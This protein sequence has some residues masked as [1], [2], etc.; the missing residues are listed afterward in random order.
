M[1][2]LFALTN[3]EIVCLLPNGLIPVGGS[4]SSGRCLTGLK[5]KDDYAV[6]SISGNDVAIH[7]LKGKK[8]G[9]F[10]LKPGEVLIINDLTLAFIEETG[11]TENKILSRDFDKEL[12]DLLDQ[13]SSTQDLSETMNNVI[14]KM[15]E[16]TSMEK[17]LLIARDVGGQFELIAHEGI[18]HD[19]NWMSESLVQKTLNSQKGISIQN[20]YGSQFQSNKSLIATGFISVQTWPLVVRGETLGIVLVGSL[21]PHSGPNIEELRRAAVFANLASLMLWFHLRD[22]KFKEE[23]RAL[24]KLQK[25]VDESPLATSDPD[26]LETSNMARKVAP[27]N[28][29]VL[30]HGETGVGKELMASW[31]HRRSERSQKPFVAVN[32]GAIPSEL[33]ESLLFGHRKGA[34]TGAQSDQIGKFQFAEGGTL[35]LDEIG[36]L[37]EILQ[38]KLLRVLQEKCIEPLGSNKSLKTDVRIIAASHRS[39]PELVAQGRFREDLYFRLAEIVLEIPPLRERPEDVVLLATSFLRDFAPEKRF[40]TE[41]WNW[42]K[43]QEWR[44]NA[45]ELQSA[46]K[47]AS[48]LAA[49]SEIKILDFTKGTSSAN[50]KSDSEN[51]LGGA[52]LEEAKAHF[53]AEKVKLALQKSGGQRNSAAGLLGVTPRTLFRYLEEIEI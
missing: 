28:L 46:V 48:I 49:C 6:I 12:F 10:S 42:M 19:E 31:I 30:I 7:P 3:R 41:A 29:S 25:N 9:S 52:T 40:S 47:R 21:K 18:N 20:I 53:I 26:L 14:K 1:N 36:D 50:A 4:E 17:G 27:T 34:F 24:K 43:C 39:L 13:F 8:K 16:V 44:G 32:C 38:V 11:L 35:F 51:W 37:A 45:R 22:L 23:I 33:L 15:I 5:E 2:K